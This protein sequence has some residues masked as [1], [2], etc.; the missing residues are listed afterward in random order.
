MSE[1][2]QSRDTTDDRYHRP[3]CPECG[4]VPSARVNHADDVM[5]LKCNQCGDVVAEADIR[6]ADLDMLTGGQ[7]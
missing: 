7:R 2:K 5:Q 6:F 1:G 3:Y 4:V